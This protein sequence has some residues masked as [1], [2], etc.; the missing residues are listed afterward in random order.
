MCRHPSGATCAS[1]SSGAGS[2]D[3]RRCSTG[4]AHVERVPIDDG[5]GD[6]VQPRGFQR[7]VLEDAVAQAP[8]LM[9][10]DGLGKEVPGFALVQPGLA[11]L[12]GCL[13][14]QPVERDQ[15]ALDTA[16]LLKGKSN[17]F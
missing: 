2:P 3:R 1:S 5:G 11:L 13:R 7:L 16:D 4:P 14:F 9:H 8:L 10:E 17:R 12:P 6:K 15:S